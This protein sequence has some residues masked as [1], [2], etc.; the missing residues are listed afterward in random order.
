VL[1]AVSPLFLLWNPWWLGLVMIAY[2][3]VANGPCILIQRYNRGRLVRVLA[4]AG[5]LDR[6]GR[7]DPER[8]PDLPRRVGESRQ[9]GPV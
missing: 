1:L 2:A 8:A 9:V 4:R 5:R 3:V 7:S 6:P